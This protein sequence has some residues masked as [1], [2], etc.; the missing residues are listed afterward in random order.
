M[1]RD[2]NGNYT[3]PSGNPVVAGTPVSDVW[4]NQTL[5]DIAEALSDSL[6]R[7][8]EGGM[9]VGFEN[10]AG[11]ITA[12]G[13]TW[14]DETSAGFYRAGAGDFRYAIG[15]VDMFQI[16][17][18]AV[19]FNKA[20]NGAAGANIASASTVNLSAATGN[21]VHIT[22]TTTITAVTLAGGMFRT[23]I[24]DDALTLTHHA[25]NN[26]LPG[27]ANITTAAGD[28]AVYW[29]DGT[30]VWCVSYT[31]A[32]GAP[33]AT[34]TTGMIMLWS[35]T[36]ATIPAGWALCNGSNGTPD[37]RDKFIIGASSDD[38]GVAKTNITGSLTQTGGSKDAVNVSHTH[39]ATVTDPGH[40]HTGAV[41]E[42][43]FGYAGGGSVY[44]R[45][46]A[47]VSVTGSS[48]TG[49]TV[50]N[51]TEGVSGTNQNLPPYY[52]LAYIMK[53]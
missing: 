6:S 50:S 9:L 13:I 17:S 12:P 26:N 49:I 45:V 51:S 36:I 16:T 30:T 28:R 27:A 7:S 47:G 40:N 21:V 22:G 14:T 2:I 29:S 31:R 48:V 19:K 38:A 41:Y 37:L 10:A 18:T 3:L 34:F 43:D 11:N 20:I 33:V 15:G 24:F 35:G 52:A 4:A 32:T 44:G 8:G 42:S 46:F 1:P 25:T 23:V 5:A 53:L 39:T